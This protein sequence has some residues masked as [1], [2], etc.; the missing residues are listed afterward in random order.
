VEK[1][2]IKV[3]D[4]FG[5]LA[6][7]I[8]MILDDIVD[9]AVTCLV[10]FVV[11]LIITTFFLSPFRIDGTSMYP[12]ISDNAVGVS[13]IIDRR[14]NGIQRF[15]IV[16]IK[17]NDEE[18]LVKRV[19]GLP[20]ETIRYVNDV[21]YVNDVM[22]PE[23]FLVEEYVEYQKELHNRKNFTNNVGEVT[24]AKDEYYCLGDNRLV[25]L[26]SR[27]YGPFKVDQIFSKGAFI[28]FPFS[29]FGKAD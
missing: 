15:D 9:I 28:I 13:S 10:T 25:S 26:D 5:T 3:A 21:L 24:L 22:I 6:L 12:T 14:I 1:L 8:I 20:G 23:D 2:K 27:M 29:N 16:I 18:N 4:L 19:I 17:L 11:A 7:R